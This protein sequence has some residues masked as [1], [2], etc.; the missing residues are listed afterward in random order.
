M[1]LETPVIAVIGHTKSGKTTVIENLVM[2]LREKGYRVATAKHIH[3][4]GFSIDT[5]GKNTWRHAAAGANPVISVSDVETAIMIKNGEDNFALEQIFRFLPEIDVVLLEGFSH[6]VL[7]DERVGKIVCA[8]NRQE[9]E[10]YREKLRGE[11]IA[12]CSYQTAEPPI[13][14]INEDFPVLAERA[15]KFVQ[16]ETEIS[17]TFNQLPMLDCKKCGYASCE[18]FAVAVYEGKA[19]ISDCLPLE[20]KAKLKTKL[21]VN[22]VEIPIQPFVSKIIRSSVLGM[23][24]SL[25]GVSIKGDE[26]I[27][28]KISS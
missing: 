19:K 3:K 13:L 9:Y 15:L 14:K 25:K 18:Q 24:S 21:I 16:R 5:E 1:R 22:N 26:S 11:A 23:I 20:P 2:K 17:K 8:K 27:Q 12:F 10:D 6:I 4:K 28:I 7:N